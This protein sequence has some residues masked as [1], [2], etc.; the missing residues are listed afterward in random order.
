MYVFFASF[1]W[2]PYARANS[3]K[4]TKESKC[5]IS[6][7]F[8][9]RLLVWVCVRCAWMSMWAGVRLCK[10]AN[11]R[12]M[13]CVCVC[14]CSDEYIPLCSCVSVHALIVLLWHSYLHTCSDWGSRKGN[15]SYFN[16]EKKNYGPRN[17]LGRGL[18]LWVLDKPKRKNKL[19]GVQLPSNAILKS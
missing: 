17:S 15:C 2:F 6:S 10:C 9:I 8:S 3:G 18:L 1:T 16:E 4:P 11:V 5:G 14:I 12:L 13:V 7:S 19:L